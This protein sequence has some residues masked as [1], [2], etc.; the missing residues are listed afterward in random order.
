MILIKKMELAHRADVL[1]MMRDFYSSNAVL[2]N[3][4]EEIF[5]A[6]FNACIGD[7]VFLEGFVF[8]K[9]GEI[10][11]YSMLSKGFST[12][13]GKNRIWIED[14]YIKEKFRGQGIGGRFIDFVDE[15][16]P[17]HVIRLEVEEENVPAV[18]AY[19]KRGFRFI[20]YKEMIKN[21]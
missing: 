12:E 5:S 17:N 21:D 3:G 9:N 15:N 1:E 8:E 13:S 11:G 14:L 20:E 2:S 16:Y 18:E 4:S 6:D 10:A 7:N 19:K